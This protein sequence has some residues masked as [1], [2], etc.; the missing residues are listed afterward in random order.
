MAEDTS[1]AIPGG[2]QPIQPSQEAAPETPT[3][4]GT[5]PLE[6]KEV[7][8]PEAP[9][10]G[11]LIDSLNALTNP[12][13]PESNGSFLERLT[14]LDSGENGR[15]PD[16]II[17]LEKKRP[18]KERETELFENLPPPTRQER[19]A[20]LLEEA[21]GDEI[22][23]GMQGI[24]VGIAEMFDMPF[25]VVAGIMRMMPIFK[26]VRGDPFRTLFGGIGSTPEKGKEPTSSIYHIGKVAGNTMATGGFAPA[27]AKIALN[28]ASGVTKNILKSVGQTAL[29]APKTFV[30]TEGIGAVGAGAGI[31]FAKT[32]FPDSP[33]IEFIFGTA[34]GFAPVFMPVRIA[35]S[36]GVAIRDKFRNFKQKGRER[37]LEE[38]K[39]ATFDTSKSVENLENPD[40]PEGARPSA[41]Q[42]SRDPG[43]MG[44]E[45]ALH[46]KSQ[47]SIFDDDQEIAKMNRAI[48]E[49]LRSDAAL[50]ERTAATLAD[51]RAYSAQLL[52]TN[53]RMA[54]LEAKARIEELGKSATAEQMDAIARQEIEKVRAIAKN[55]QELLWNM[56][57]KKAPATSSTASSVMRDLFRRQSES[58]TFKGLKNLPKHLELEKFLGRIHVGKNKNRFFKGGELS[59]KSN[60][61]EVHGLRSDVLAAI[62]AERAGDSPHK[63]QNISILTEIEEALLQDLGAIPGDVMPDSQ[64]LRNALDFSRQFN[65][66]FNQGIIGKLRGVDKSGTAAIADELTLVTA[67]GGKPDKAAENVRQMI[68]A[69]K[70]VE[71][72]SEPSLELM[73]AFEDFIKRDFAR[74]G[75]IRGGE[76]NPELG[77]KYVEANSKILDEFPELKEAISRAIDSGDVRIIRQRVSDK[78]TAH[79]SVSKMSAATLFL[80]KS[81]RQAFESLEDMR[82]EAFG[83]EVTRMLEKVKKGGDEALEG[84]QM[85]FFDWLRRRSMT[86]ALDAEGR[87]FISGIKIKALMRDERIIEMTNRILNEGQIERLRKIVN[88]AEV[89]DMQRFTKAFDSDVLEN[90]ESKLLTT[91]MRVA[92]AKT[93]AALSQATGGGAGGLQTAAIMSERF[94]AAVQGL[95]IED[96]A[97]RFLMDVF[98]D[99]SGELLKAA[100]TEVRTNAQLKQVTSTLNAWAASVAYQQGDKTLAENSE[101]R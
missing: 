22:R 4:A 16:A 36:A 10:Q 35:T 62:R 26:D 27:G 101:E 49:S 83:K 57:D 47:K 97:V 60:V 30:A 19:E 58:R 66:I 8:S 64:D 51:Q 37:G 63:A 96:P 59:K 43:L 7:E 78:A 28:A 24:N 73:G 29:N 68:R 76:I 86:G 17:H 56:V 15:G 31:E 18:R 11:S 12:Q 95:S 89:M 41:A 74:G 70:G 81:P 3:L 52:E 13:T 14:A 53:L 71:G 72:E 38:L 92:G 90:G 77:R 46:Q 84:F 42:A 98:E 88:H 21:K 25:E 33:S 20:T 65:K 45:K 1:I 69:A 100:L 82:P 94:K 5:P 93:G 34:G 40:L 39:K 67:F 44:L 91:V 32:N 2:P 99:E 23:E 55:D 75:R 54:R 50:V 79:V 80:E 6:F 48:D 61:G 9:S 87:E 85:S